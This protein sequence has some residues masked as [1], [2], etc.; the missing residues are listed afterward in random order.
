MSADANTVLS[1]AIDC[2]E[3]LDKRPRPMCRD[4]ADEC[5]VCPNGGLECDM[6]KLIADARAA[7]A[8]PV[9]AASAATPGA[10]FSDHIRWV[11][12]GVKRGHGADGVAIANMQAWQEAHS[13]QLVADALAKGYAKKVSATECGALAMLVI[14]KQR[15]EKAE[16]EREEAAAARD[17]NLQEALNWQAKCEIAESA[18]AQVAGGQPGDA[19]IT[20]SDTSPVA[21][22]PSGPVTWTPA[23]ELRLDTALHNVFGTPLPAPVAG[24]AYRAIGMIVGDDVHGWHLAIDQ[25]EDWG[26]I[27]HHARVYVRTAPPAISTSKGAA[28]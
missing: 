15:A 20:A 12:A 19:G 1:R 27:G 3:I 28:E 4:C 11:L 5:G 25:G 7:I 21:E 18:L 8:P 16:A 26:L 9:A 23:D 6:R 24:P 13:A 17:W 2:L 10:S 14:E 22:A